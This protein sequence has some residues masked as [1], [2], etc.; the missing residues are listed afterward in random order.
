[1]RKHGHWKSCE[2]RKR[3]EHLVVKSVQLWAMSKTCSHS[4][5][6]SPDS[7]RIAMC[8]V[9]VAFDSMPKH[10]AGIRMFFFLH[11]RRHSDN[12][13]VFFRGW[14]FTIIASI[15]SQVYGFLSY[16]FLHTSFHRQDV[17][18]LMHANTARDETRGS[19]SQNVRWDDSYLEPCFFERL[20]WSCNYLFPAGEIGSKLPVEGESFFSPSACR[21]PYLVLMFDDDL[22][23]AWQRD[24]NPFFLL[25]R[26][27]SGKDF[28]HYLFVGRHDSRTT[29]SSSHYLVP[30]FLMIWFDWVDSCD[31]DERRGWMSCLMC[32]CVTWLRGSNVWTT[33]KKGYLIR[34]VKLDIVLHVFSS[35]RRDTQ[36]L[37]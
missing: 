28:S 34:W 30:L 19:R 8:T 3:G 11:T 4:D 24:R 27:E 26:K 29:R 17:I 12:Y 14:G 33:A 13:N 6:K 20:Y 35:R 22:F 25:E 1:M 9:C 23:D 5:S 32:V 10:V 18:V 2:E 16:R 37:N 15:A 21:C 31:A 36:L 7:F